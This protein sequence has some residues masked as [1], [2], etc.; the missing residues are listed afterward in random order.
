MTDRC[1]KRCDHGS[2]C[3]LDAGHVPV[4]RHES[5]H[6][7]VFYDVDPEATTDRIDLPR[8]DRSDAEHTRKDRQ[9]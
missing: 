4:D 1:G 8:V 7:C 3:M 6:G 2:P 9:G 5:E